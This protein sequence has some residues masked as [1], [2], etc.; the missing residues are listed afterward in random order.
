M[1]DELIGQASAVKAL[2]QA[3]IDSLKT[4]NGTTTT[5]FSQSWL[6]TGPPGSG[7]STAAKLFAAA[8]Q[9]PQSG[10]GS[11]EIC[12]NVLKGVYPDVKTV[13]PTGITYLVED[14][15]LLIQSSALMPAVGQWN[16]VILEDADR[17]TDTAANALLKSIEEPAR[18]TMWILCAPSSQ[19]VISTIR[20]RCRMVNLRMPPFDEIAQLLQKRDGVDAA[21]AKFSA[22]AALGHVGRA[23]LLATNPQLREIRSEILQLPFELSDLPNCFKAAETLYSTAVAEADAETEEKDQFEHEQLL[24][25]Y[26]ASA[27]G[28]SK[29]R[30]QKMTSTAIKDL[31]KE[32]KNR[33]KRISRDRLDL[34]LIELLAFYRDVLVI[35]SSA[36]LE[37]FHEQHRGSIEKMANATSPQTTI[38]R[39][40]AIDEART[41]LPSEASP[42]LVIEAMMIQL[43][44]S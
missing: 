9:C 17:L 11:C 4:A 24:E 15:R 30:I 16:I 3:A 12:L 35:Q 34:S 14:V 19:D 1:W 33:H 42:L 7:R 39:I 2:K 41:L 28:V 22:A 44:R 36:E 37:L 18:S 38:K 29:S 13:L 25:S 31:N 27:G 8:L 10:C 20:S 6:I 23:K 21:M 43:A 40:E 5:G 26:G 32:Q